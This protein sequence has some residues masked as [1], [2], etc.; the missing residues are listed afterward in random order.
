[1]T[2]PAENFTHLFLNKIKAMEEK[3]Q[4]VCDDDDDDEDIIIIIIIIQEQFCGI[5]RRQLDNWFTNRLN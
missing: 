4:L 5:T 3:E 1:M 2:L